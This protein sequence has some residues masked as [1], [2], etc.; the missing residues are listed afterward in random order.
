[1][2]SVDWRVPLGE[3]R[4]ILGSSKGVQGNLEPAVLLARDRDFIAHRTQQVLDEN[5]GRAGHVFNLG[6]G[7]L[8]DTPVENA[9]FVVDYVHSHTV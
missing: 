3:A 8:R 7:I 5:G 6:H 2:F 4:E 9:K 1:M